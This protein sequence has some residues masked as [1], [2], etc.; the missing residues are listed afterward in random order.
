MD[1]N[2]LIDIIEKDPTWHDWSFGQLEEAARLGAIVINH[3]VVAE[4]A[5]QF[6][7]LEEFLTRIDA[8]LVEI[9]PFTDTAAMFAGQAFRTYRKERPG[10]KSVLADF[11]IGGHAVALGA[12]VLTRD[13]RFYARYFPE[14]T[15]ITP[16]TDNG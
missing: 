9:E 6:G 5:P 14:L 2:V 15:L 10:S 7:S 3:I 4:V 11:L 16:E 1:S 12:D 13:P 8:I